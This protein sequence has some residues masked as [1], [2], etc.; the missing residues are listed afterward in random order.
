MMKHQHIEKISKQVEKWLT[1]YEIPVSVYGVISAL[2]SLGYLGKKQRE[3]DCGCVFDGDGN[4]V[5]VC[6]NH[7]P[8]I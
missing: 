5:M 7:Q 4:A 6:V 1:D 3:R 2:V 8:E